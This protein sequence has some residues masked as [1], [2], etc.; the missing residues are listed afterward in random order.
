MSGLVSSAVPGGSTAAAEWMWSRRYVE[1]LQC[2]RM[3]FNLICFCN[4]I[5]LEFIVITLLRDSLHGQTDGVE[6]L[7]PRLGWVRWSGAQPAIPAHTYDNV[8]WQPSQANERA[9]GIIGYSRRKFMGGLCKNLFWNNSISVW[10]GHQLFQWWCSLA[11]A[12]GGR[13]QR[14]RDFWCS[15]FSKEEVGC[16]GDTSA[17]PPVSPPSWFLSPANM[18]LMTTTTSLC[19]GLAHIIL[20]F[21]CDMEE[22]RY[23]QS[24]P[25]GQYSCWV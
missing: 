23:S 11:A 15:K 20:L 21:S 19:S 9:I 8:F 25:Y 12:A 18:T 14:R 3:L 1:G 4:D 24:A 6:W 10:L 16:W 7:A 22:Q 2:H 13:R 5:I 17:P